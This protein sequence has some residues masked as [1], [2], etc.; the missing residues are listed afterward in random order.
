M[1][2]I[3]LLVS[4]LSP[5]SSISLWLL[6]IHQAPISAEVVFVLFLSSLCLDTP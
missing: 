3:T 4:I 5:L 6:Q 2:Y 1:T